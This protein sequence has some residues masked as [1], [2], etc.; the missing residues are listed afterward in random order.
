MFFAKVHIPVQF[1][2]HT[3]IDVGLNEFQKLELIA[4]N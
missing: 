1:K 2:M 3:K 4:P